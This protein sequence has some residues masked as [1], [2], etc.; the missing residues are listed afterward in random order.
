MLKILERDEVLPII[1]AVQ[2]IQ[3]EK[4]G[5]VYILVNGEKFLGLYSSFIEPG[6]ITIDEFHGQCHSK[7]RTTQRGD[8]KATQ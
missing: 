7:R 6:K 8:L 4:S 5:N 2:L 3:D 1:D